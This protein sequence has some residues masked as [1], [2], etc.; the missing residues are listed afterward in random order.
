[1]TYRIAV[2]GIEHESTSFIPAPTPVEEFQRQTVRGDALAKLGDANTIVD[3]FVRGVCDHGMKLV[4]LLWV[5]GISGG[6]PTLATYTM[7]KNDL[8]ERLR[9]AL[10]VDGV[11]LS[12]HGSFAAVGIDDAD[13]DILQ[14]VRELVGS[15]CPV[16]A[17][18][19]FHSN[20]S[21]QMVAAADVGC[22]RTTSG[23][24]S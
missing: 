24:G 11:L 1:M 14:S 16:I 23:V 4:P 3:G 20:I 22:D 2:G 15:E 10:P 18:H 8:L 13:G 12:L 17:V 9:D 6:L 5:K 21:R 7:L 19:D